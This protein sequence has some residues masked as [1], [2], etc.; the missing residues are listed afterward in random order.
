MV[1]R[2]RPLGVP[3]PAPVGQRERWKAGAPTTHLVR[4]GH[5]QLNRAGILN[6]DPSADVHLDDEGRAQAAAAQSWA[7]DVASVVTSSL[8]RSRETA[9]LLFGAA[10]V[11]RRTD[12][13]LDEIDYGV[14]EGRPWSD[15]GTWLR[16]HG[17]DARPSGARESWAE[18]MR[19]VLDGLSEVHELP[20]PRIVIGH[21]FWIAALRGLVVADQWPHVAD[22]GSV[23][24][25][26]PTTVSDAEL[27]RIVE[28]AHD[29]LDRSRRGARG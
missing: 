3:S 7:S 14:F 28:R 17:P 23:R 4:H 29:L 19:R 24:W 1:E 25:L 8:V 2:E 9:D 15:Y 11:L 22:I 5:C 16:E 6:G 18:A 20:S 26:S 21:G 12:P 10:A 27:A 13:R